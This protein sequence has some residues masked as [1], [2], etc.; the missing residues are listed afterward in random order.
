MRRAVLSALAALGLALAPLAAVHPVRVEGRSMLP[1]LHPGER[2]WVLRRALAGSPRP[3]Q[4]WLVEGPE[5][6]VVKRLIA[7]PGQAVEERD[8][9]LWV[10]G[11]RLEE[12][13]VRWSG[14]ASGGPWQGGCF[15]AGDNRPESRDCRS[16]GSLP[17]SALRGRVLGRD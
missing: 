5:G 2:I 14:R 3:G 10:E 6:P 7:L 16:W 4:V 13:W 11:R 8:G 17:E 9:E 15:L 1:A 12:P